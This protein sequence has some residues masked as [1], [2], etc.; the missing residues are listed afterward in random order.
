VVPSLCSFIAQGPPEWAVSSSS[1]QMSCRPSHHCVERKHLQPFSPCRTFS[2]ASY[3][4]VCLLLE[5]MDSS[6]AAFQSAIKTE[7][8]TTSKYP[9][10]PTAVSLGKCRGL[11]H[12]LCVYRV[13]KRVRSGESE[14]RL[15]HDLHLQQAL[16]GIS[17]CIGERK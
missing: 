14:V 6:L 17:C 4:L 13:C 2:L 1:E 7:I 8:S 12:H 16:S 5:H 10:L 9:S 3:R 15:P 11:G